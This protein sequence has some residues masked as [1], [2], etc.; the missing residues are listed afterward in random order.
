MF[1]VVDGQQRLTTVSLLLLA[2]RNLLKAGKVDSEDPNLAQRI[3]EEY[4]VDR[5]HPEATRIKLKPGQ[6]D[7]EAFSKL[8]GEESKRVVDSQI[9]K[10]Y[11]YF[12]QRILA[13][14]ITVDEIVEAIEKLLS[15]GEWHEP[16]SGRQRRLLPRQCLGEM[17]CY[18]TGTVWI[19]GA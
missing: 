4:L 10:N 12:V 18:E 2:I 17:Q 5:F 15:F 3:Y 16:D 19:S 14:E 11:D 6:N 8:F 1:L 13:N 9:T 7:R